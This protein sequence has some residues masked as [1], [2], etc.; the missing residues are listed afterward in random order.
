ME[1]S[2]LGTE[3][4][5]GGGLVSVLRQRMQVSFACS[6]IA[7]VLSSLASQVPSLPSYHTP[8]PSPLLSHPYHLPGTSMSLRGI[9]A[10]YVE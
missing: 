6:L 1:V 4:A 9:F 2:F 5:Y 8:T 10:M 7:A 3:T